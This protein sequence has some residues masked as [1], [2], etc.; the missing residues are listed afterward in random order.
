MD[1]ATEN[2]LYEWKDQII[3]SVSKTIKESLATLNDHLT[4][5]FDIKISGIEKDIQS[6][7]GQ[8][9]QH[10]EEMKSEKEAN[11]KAHSDILD[12]VDDK[13]NAL[14]AEISG[15]DRRQST[16]EGVAKGMQDAKGENNNKKVL[17]WTAAGVIVAIIVFL[18]GLGIAE[19]RDNQPA[20]TPKEITA[21][22][23]P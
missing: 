5:V 21:P 9:L 13:I 3:E 16:D 17:F 14:R 2:K 19:V 22:P 18:F 4:T 7:K 1:A 12:K 8:S 11:V 15:L 6:L 20:I 10:Y 23:A